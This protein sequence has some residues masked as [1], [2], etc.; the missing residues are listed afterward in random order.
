MKATFQ[1]PDFPNSNFEIETSVW[2]GKHKL[3]MDT[4]QL[5]QSKEKGKPFLIPSSD[6]TVVK[7]F[8]KPALPDFM[9]MLEI[10]GIKN[11]TAKRLTTFQYVIALLPFS[12]VVYSNIIFNESIDGA[13]VGTMIR[14]AISGA[15]SALASIINV[16]ILRKEGNEKLKYAKVSGIIMTSYI[17]YTLV[18]RAFL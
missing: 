2:T 7:A 5:E 3:F 12:L 18:T 9:P 10:N 4:V 16:S 17:V 6:G 1:L 8:P 14:G 15:I 13:I 11:Q